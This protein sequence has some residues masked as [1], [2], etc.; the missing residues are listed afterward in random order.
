M[1][2][3]QNLEDESTEIQVARQQAAQMPLEQLVWSL[4]TY[5]DGIKRCKTG[6]QHAFKMKSLEDNTNV[7]GWQQIQQY[8]ILAMPHTKRPSIAE[9][10]A[11]LNND[12]DS[13]LNSK[14][15]IEDE[16]TRRGAVIHRL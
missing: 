8:V 15:V 12:L 7:M 1:T 10:R 9:V 11:Q 13:L 4:I 5:E 3:H 6:V 14:R 16:L 2:F